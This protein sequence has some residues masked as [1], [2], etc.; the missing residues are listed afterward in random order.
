MTK[1]NLET[2]PKCGGDACYTTKLNA[3]AKNYF[4][5]G[6]GFTSNDLMN[7]GEFDFEQ[8]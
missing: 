2:C 8:Y 3:T 1:D 7:I 5:F 6:C 4:C